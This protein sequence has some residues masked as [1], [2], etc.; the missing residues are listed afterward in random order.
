MLLQGL[1]EVGTVEC[2]DRMDDGTPICLAVTIDRRNGSAIFDFEGTGP[3]VY[4]N[5]NAPPAVTTSAVIY[6]LRCLVKQDIPLNGGCLAPVT[7]KARARQSMCCMLA[8]HFGMPTGRFAI[9]RI[10]LH[11]I[12]KTS[13]GP[14][15]RFIDRA[16][17]VS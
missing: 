6:S 17:A 11:S 13:P 4:G 14:C 15:P 3:Q 7:I 10:K 9:P 16:S 12:F 1:P 5:T 2:A 8:S